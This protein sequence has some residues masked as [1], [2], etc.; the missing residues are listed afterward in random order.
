MRKYRLAKI[1]II[2][3]HSI[4][5]HLRD[6]SDENQHRLQVTIMRPQK[7]REL[8]RYDEVDIRLLNKS[9]DAIELTWTHPA[10][11]VCL[12]DEEIGLYTI[13]PKD[14]YEADSCSVIFQ[15]NKHYFKFEPSISR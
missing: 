12:D 15:N 6:D 10:Y 13:A 5:V 9:G 2:K 1:S 14:V 8:V 3:G 4:S 7:K 11:F